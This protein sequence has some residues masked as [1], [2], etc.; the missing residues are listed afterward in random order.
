[1]S[2]LFDFNRRRMHIHFSREV[3]RTGKFNHLGKY[4]L[5]LTKLSAKYLNE[6]CLTKT[7]LKKLSTPKSGAFDHKVVV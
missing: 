1:M 2:T 4:G 7:G 3:V 6:Q 5:F